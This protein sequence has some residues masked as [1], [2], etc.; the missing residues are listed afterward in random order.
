MAGGDTVAENIDL[1]IIIFALTLTTCV[2]HTQ[3]LAITDSIMLTAIKANVCSC[4]E[5]ISNKNR[6]QYSTLRMNAEVET[7]IQY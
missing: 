4:Q 7:R 1:K 2:I 3:R 6:F 5:P